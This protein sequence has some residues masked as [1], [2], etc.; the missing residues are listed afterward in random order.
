MEDQSVLLT[1]EPSHQPILLSK[2]NA[3]P[4]NA[5][6]F[7]SQSFSLLQVEGLPTLTAILQS[8]DLRQGCWPLLFVPFA[9]CLSSIMRSFQI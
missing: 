9:Y 1:A 3:T 8:S 6:A 4:S 2:S 7:M 5:N